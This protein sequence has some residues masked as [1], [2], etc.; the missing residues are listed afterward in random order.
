MK[1][2]PSFDGVVL[3]LSVHFA[4]FLSILFKV[5]TVVSDIA[6]LDANFHKNRRALFGVWRVLVGNNSQ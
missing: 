1:I 3:K 2:L 4:A 5:F 6:V